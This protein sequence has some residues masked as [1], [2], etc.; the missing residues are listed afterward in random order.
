MWSCTPVASMSIIMFLGRQQS[1][2]VPVNKPVFSFLPPSAMPLSVSGEVPYILG[3]ARVPKDECEHENALDPNPG[4]LVIVSIN[5]K[6]QEG[7]VPP[8]LEPSPHPHQATNIQTSSPRLL[9]PAESTFS[10]DQRR[11]PVPDMAAAGLSV[12]LWTARRMY[13]LS[14]ALQ[15]L[16]R[17]GNWG[18]MEEKLY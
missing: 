5:C 7:L 2:R 14:V 11:K 10:C 3:M 13:S 17:R 4:W 8:S 15:F 18:R 9:T 6:S 12:T 1:F 16:E